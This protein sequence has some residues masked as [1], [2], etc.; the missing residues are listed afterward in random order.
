MPIVIR[1]ALYVRSLVLPFV[2]MCVCLNVC[3]LCPSNM[4]A[5]MAS[6]SICFADNIE[7][8]FVSWVL[9]DI[10]FIDSLRPSS[11][12]SP[13]LQ[14][15]YSHCPYLFSSCA[16]ESFNLSYYYKAS[17]II[18]TSLFGPTCPL[19]KQYLRIPYFHQP[20]KMKILVFFG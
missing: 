6:R 7:N 9:P 1:I 12:I 20:K 15:L 19:K 18:S 8:H 13:A 16:F 5:P 11:S 3:T 17:F 10:Q 14:D 4:T 2:R